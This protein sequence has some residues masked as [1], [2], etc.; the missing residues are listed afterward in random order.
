MADD[1]RDASRPGGRDASV[2]DHRC[3]PRRLQQVAQRFDRGPGLGEFGLEADQALPALRAL[4]DDTSRAG[5]LRFAAQKAVK[6]IDKVS[7]TFHEETLPDVIAD[8]GDDNPEI[9]ASAAAACCS[10]C[11]AV[12]VTNA[13]SFG[14]NLCAR[15][16]CAVTTSTG[17]TSFWR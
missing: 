12:T 11:S 6:A 17:E 1:R 2:L 15:S 13:F 3:V 7:R 9:R 5:T 10:A 8:L 14:C 16:R 4:A